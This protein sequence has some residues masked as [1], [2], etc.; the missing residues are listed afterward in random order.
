MESGESR[1]KRGREERFLSCALET[2]EEFEEYIDQQESSSIHPQQKDR[3]SSSRTNKQLLSKTQE[4]RN[5]TYPFVP[6]VKA[7]SSSPSKSKLSVNNEKNAS[8]HPANEE[9]RSPPSKMQKCRI[10]ENEKEVSESDK[11]IE[12]GTNNIYEDLENEILMYGNTNNGV[13][14]DMEHENKEEETGAKKEDK[15]VENETITDD[16]GKSASETDLEPE[17]KKKMYRL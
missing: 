15:M 12:E 14:G 13:K 9:D 1:P 16:N 17:P 4:N 8:I 6:R 3:R 11:E 5:K 7:R 10:M 2:Q